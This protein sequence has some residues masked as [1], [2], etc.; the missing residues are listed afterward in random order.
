MTVQRRSPSASQVKAMRIANAGN[1]ERRWLMAMISMLALERASSFLH[2]NT[3]AKLG[4]PS[5]SSSNRIQL[6][7]GAYLVDGPTRRA[8]STRLEAENYVNGFRQTKWINGDASPGDAA[9]NVE[10]MSLL[11][12]DVLY[13]RRSELVYDPVQDRYRRRK[14][15]NGFEEEALDGTPGSKRRGIQ[16]IWQTV[17]AP[18]LSV[19]FLPSGVTPN[20]YNFMRWRVLQR[21]V[22]ANLHVFGT[23]SLLMGLGIK[24][25]SSQLGA[26]S[27]A[28]KWVLKDALG[29]FVRMAWASRMGRRFDSDAK[30]WRFR[31]AFVY[32]L[33][34]FLEITTYIIPSMFLVWATLAN[35][36]KQVSMLT[37]SS[38]R[39][40]IYNSFRDGSRENIGDITAKG[41]AQI[42][43][44]D[45]LGIGSGVTLSRVVGTSV[46][47]VL[48]VYAVLQALEILCMYKQIR[49]VVYRVL[50][51]ERMAAVI[52]DFLD[53]TLTPDGKSVAVVNGAEPVSPPLE[54]A[55]AAHASDATLHTN[56]TTIEA[57]AVVTPIPSTSNAARATASDDDM[58]GIKT[59]QQMA[60]TER[61]FLPPLHLA[62]RP[63]SFGSLGRAKLSPQE[64][65]QLLQIFAKERFLLI[66]GANVKRPSAQPNKSSKDE[67]LRENCH[68]VLHK[69]ATNADI[70]KATFALFLLRRKLA[71]SS[72]RLDPVS[73]RSSD[74]YDIIESAL[75]DTDQLFGLFRRK[76]S[77]QGW[78]SP[79]RSMFG[80]VHMRAEWPLA[81][82]NER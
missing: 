2:S 46:Q 53:A 65:D 19:A 39:T 33:G 22:N 62:R 30:R 54:A 79:A 42:A 55:T 9:T 76:L 67:S 75:S 47:S 11:E 17:V 20:Y 12:L 40:A 61:I 56:A 15:V 28:L 32:A 25:S 6:P 77:K 78:E 10:T 82:T 45:L 23:Q 81:T 14:N 8:K 49:T 29:K 52:E 41:E 27:A 44:V 13:D 4:P 80:R 16:N 38:T 63:T 73:M 69:E 74:C 36:C 71:A 51:F 57:A 35:C 64:L 37:S 59:P 70:V 48:G 24:S 26:L 60:E 68:I 43:I 58:C 34:N 31:S 18:R 66:V 5:L 50:N 7:S 3:P 72:S 21:F 1:M